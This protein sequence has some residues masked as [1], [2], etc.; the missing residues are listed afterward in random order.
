MEKQ[1]QKAVFNMAFISLDQMY[2]AWKKVA[3]WVGGTSED[4]PKV[5]V[6][7]FP[8]Y[9]SFPTVQNVQIA[10]NYVGYSTNEKPLNV[11]KG[12]TFLELDTKEVFIF[13]GVDWVVF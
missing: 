5:E 12:D 11:N 7:N 13:D 4:K 10:G 3:D 1:K 9:P 8:E 2:S 6:T